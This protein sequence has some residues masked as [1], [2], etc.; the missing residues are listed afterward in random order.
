MIEALLGYISRR[1]VI[2]GRGFV[3][4]FD[5]LLLLAFIFNRLF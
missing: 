4:L 3:N 1:L 5:I 2:W